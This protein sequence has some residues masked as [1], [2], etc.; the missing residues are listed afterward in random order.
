M[1]APLLLIT[2]IWGQHQTLEPLIAELEQHF[3]S[4][5]VLDPYSGQRFVFNNEAEAYEYFQRRCTDKIYQQKVAD[6]LNSAAQPLNVLAFSAGANAIWPLLASSDNVAKAALVYGNKIP[7]DAEL[8]PKCPTQL[9]L[10]QDDVGVKEHQSSLN[11]HADLVISEQQHGYFNPRSEHFDP[12]AATQDL[13]IL[14]RY[15]LR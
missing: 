12:V 4:V 7:L 9:W 8:E 13:A 2:D 6:C 1:T 15:L 3:P 5:A 10:C 11:Q 14:I